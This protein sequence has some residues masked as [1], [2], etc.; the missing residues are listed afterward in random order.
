VQNSNV[1]LKVNETLQLAEKEL[2]IGDLQVELKNAKRDCSDHLKQIEELKSVHCSLERELDGANSRLGQVVRDC[3]TA[4]STIDSLNQQ[5]PQ[6]D[7]LREQAD[8][9]RSLVHEGEVKD[10]TVADLQ[11][12]LG[13]LKAANQRLHGHQVDAE[14]KVMEIAEL[15]VRLQKAEEAPQQLGALQQELQNFKEQIASSKDARERVNALECELRQKDDRMNQ[16]NID[17]ADFDD[18]RQRLNDLLTEMTHCRRDYECIE[19]TL[20]VTME[21]AART[22]TLVK[23]ITLQRDE[24]SELKAKLAE[25]ERISE[26]VPEMHAQVNQFSETFSN[27]RRE[28][29]HAQEAG[30][31]L[32]SI[33]TANA[34]FQ[35]RIVELQDQAAVA[36]QASDSL[37]CLSEEVQQKDARIVALEIELGRLKTKQQQMEVR[38]ASPEDL[39]DEDVPQET[40][41]LADDSLVQQ[42]K[43]G[44]DNDYRTV[45]NETADTIRQEAEP[46]K[47]RKRAN[48][49]VS[50]LQ[51][52]ASTSD[53]LVLVRKTS[54][55]AGLMVDAV[56][57]TPPANAVD[58]C[59]PSVQHLDE[60]NLIPESQPHGNDLDKSLSSQTM[61]DMFLDDALSSS[62]LSDVGALFGS[63]DQDQP[64]KSRYH[65][66]QQHIGQLDD[67]DG[68]ED[69]EATEQPLGHEE[70][71]LSET[72]QCPE[73]SHRDRELT[74]LSQGSRPVSSSYGEPL[75]LDDL[76]GLG[77][78]PA[79]RSMNTV[80]GMQ[81]N[82]S[83]QDVLTSPVGTLPRKLPRK[84]MQPRPTAMPLSGPDVKAAGLIDH[85]QHLAKG[86]SPRRL[87][88]S[89]AS[90]RTNTRGSLHDLGE[91]T[92]N[93]RPATPNLPAKERHQP[94]S[95]IKR[96]SET[97]SIV[98]ENFPTE[99][100][101][102]KRNLSNMD[103]A[104]RPGTRSWSVNSSTSA[105]VGE[106]FGRLRQ[107]SISTTS[108]R[109]T[110]VGKKAPASGG[111]KQR[112]KK[113]RGLKSEQWLIITISRGY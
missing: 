88:N 83:I 15:N 28:L 63:T 71:L 22:P 94:N 89:R 70:S 65:A 45:E 1:K 16:L 82:P 111:S 75:L 79:S 31:E 17:I 62:P 7:E 77:S 108:S 44:Y 23:E 9:M 101:R 29:E 38:E 59:A 50:S 69:V 76:E 43:D 56:N 11:Q 95:A 34:T 42:A 102:S 66:T 57:E 26:A 52:N 61:R 74:K 8:R 51:V 3:T 35:Q 60:A 64:A 80:P 24:I 113:P 81:L 21:E 40:C 99:K 72:S 55:R 47:E 93:V 39:H 54:E 18:T 67:T 19:K 6:I 46:R 96:K 30:E 20:K 58:G 110:I 100:K 87:R 78:L 4:R 106:T 48:R 53:H 104:S 13:S 12:E 14:N 84:S 27:L 85:V 107:S 49:S 103:V 33:K 86:P 5:L 41:R 91:D 92:V 32:R 97:A 98:D 105:R 109:N 25:A 112:P 2:H 36:E 10:G 37:K 73:A 90:P 68:R